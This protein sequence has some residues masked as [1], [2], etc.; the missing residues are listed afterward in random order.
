[1]VTK[2]KFEEYFGKFGKAD[3][4]KP[5]Q[6]GDID[7][8]FKAIELLRKRVPHEVCKRIIG[9]VY[10][11][12]V[13]ICP[14]TDSLEYLSEEDLNILMDCNVGWDEEVDSFILFV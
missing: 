7:Y 3:K 1:M 13:Y 2:E 6:S 4:T 12:C 9:S 5:F 14:A 11:D 8:N 10:N